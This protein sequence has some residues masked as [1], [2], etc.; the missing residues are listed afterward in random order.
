MKIIKVLGGLGNQMFQYAFYLNHASNNNSKGA[1][2]LD[3]SGFGKYKLHNG[4]ELE[5]IFKNIDKKYASNHDFKALFGIFYYVSK[6]IKPAFKKSKKYIKQ[7][8]LEFDPAYL[9]LSE[10]Y[11]S[12]YWQ[13]EKYFKNVED[14]LRH[15]FKFPALDIRNQEFINNL[16]HKNT[17]SIHVRRGDYVNHPDY[18]NICTLEY[19]KKG[20][21]YFLENYEN[22]HFVIFSNEITWC[23]KNLKIS[24]VS[25][26][27]WNNNDDC[28]KDM[29]LMSLCNHNI[30]ANSSFSWWGAWLND[31]KHK[32]VI[33]P[34][35]W[36]NQNFI[37]PND[38]C[39]PQWTRI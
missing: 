13:S 17:I 19:Y 4:Y 32:T 1:S 29:Q 5:K 25:Y 6:V 22:C 8:E 9:K 11:F 20:I 16:D 28:Y 33:S 26:V 39:P 24:N 10:G 12:G 7:K 37:N 38:I 21:N 18:Q 2:F 35:K 3:I 27:D 31:N 30:I 23:R 15:H 34:T 36:V 14:I